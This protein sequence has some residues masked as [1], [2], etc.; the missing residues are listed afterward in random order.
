MEWRHTPSTTPPSAWFC[1]GFP[2]AG[3]RGF[4]F[5]FITIFPVCVRSASTLP[6]RKQSEPHHQINSASTS[7]GSPSSR[8]TRLLSN[9]LRQYLTTNQALRR[10]FWE[11]MPDDNITIYWPNHVE[12]EDDQHVV[13]DLG[14]FHLQTSESPARKSGCGIPLGGNSTS[15]WSRRKRGFH[16]RGTSEVGVAGYTLGMGA[17]HKLQVFGNC[18]SN[19]SG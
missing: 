18:V 6:G 14:R 12:P 9:V 13:N 19:G 2:L 11:L 1:Q 4:Y 5:C 8:A 16:K 15:P 3:Q 10:E 17:K 7:I